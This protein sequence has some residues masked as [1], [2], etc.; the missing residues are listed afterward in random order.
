MHRALLAALIA[1]LGLSAVPL[2]AQEPE[3]PLPVSGSLIY[4]ALFLN[5]VNGAGNRGLGL[6]FAGRVATRVGARTYLGLGGGS[7]IR[8]TRGDCGLVDCNGYV[9]S[10]SE[11]VVYQLYLQ[12]YVTRNQLFVRAGAGL[13]DTRTLFPENRILIAVSR[14]WRGAV[15][16]GLGADLRIARYVYL[17]PS[18]DFTVLPGADTGAYELG[19]GLAIGVALTLR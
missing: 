12:Q 7:W 9:G 3:V 2:G 17:T 8:V 11:A 14:R 19:S 6:R 5:R 1:I 15:S 10:Q 13:A 18:L 16:A 4:N